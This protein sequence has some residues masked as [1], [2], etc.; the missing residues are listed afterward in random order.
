M[1]KATMWVVAVG[2]MLL[3]SVVSFASLVIGTVNKDARLR[4]LITAK[5]RDNQSEHDN[6]W[7]KIQ[8]VAQCTDEQMKRMQEIYTSHAAARTGEGGK[9]SWSWVKESIPN[10]D[11]KT[12]T[13]LQN[14]V[15]SSR[16]A[17]TQRQKELLDF[18]REHDDLLSVFPT[19]QICALLGREKI[20]VTIVTSTRT[21]ES[22]KTGKDDSTNL[23]N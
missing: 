4:N 3:V 18:K 8:Q 11:T 2:V 19:A 20:D 12:F 13:N 9:P 21:E 6:M 15:T 5:Q 16:D 7:K 23:F 14:I 22:F 10:I 1:S 17:W